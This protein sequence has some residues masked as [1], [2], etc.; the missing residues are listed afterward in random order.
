MVSL[1][2]A[3]VAVASAAAA[4]TG[5]GAAASVE[6]S[7]A[8][9][10]TMY[11]VTN[12]GPGE[13]GAFINAKGQVTFAHGDPMA[14]LPPR[15]WFFDGA[16]LHEVGTLGGDFARPTGLNDV[17]QVTGISNTASGFIHAFVWS[18]KQGMTDV[19]T[20]PGST[21]SWDPAINN[22][23]EVAGYSAGE[24]TPYPHAFRWSPRSGIE[25]L[26][27]LMPGESSTSYARAINDAGLIAGNAWAGEHFYHAFVWTRSAGMVDIDTLGSNYT[28]PVAVG[29]KGQ[30]AGN[31]I[32]P[33]NNYGSVFWWTRATGMRDIGAGQVRG[34]WMLSMSSGGRIAGIFNHPDF[35]QRAMTWTLQ[36]GMRDLGTLG[37]PTSF[38]TAANNRGQVVG[39]AS[40][41]DERVHAFVWTE[42]EGMA[43]LNQRLYRPPAGLVLESALGISDNGSIIAASN[44]GLVLLRPQQACPCAH[45]AGPIV[46]PALVQVGAP[47]DTAIAFATENRTARYQVSWAWGDGTAER[48]RET[49]ASHE[50][51]SASARHTYAA[52]GIYTITAKVADQAGNS[53][54]VSRRIVVLDSSSGA[55]GGAGAVVVPA[56][57][58][59]GLTMGGGKAHFSFVTPSPA[60]AK[61]AGTKGHF[62]FSL[63]GL[64]F[65]SNEVRV[66]GSQGGSV[67]LA[68]TGTLN[69]TGRHHFTATTSAGSS[70]G[71]AGRFRVKIWHTDPKTQAEVVDYDSQAGAN[72]NAGRPLVEGSVMVQ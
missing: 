11:R 27:L 14:G 32:N 26:G 8:A 12:L 7:H 46:S 24:P 10:P 57:T 18:K 29:A 40:T 70:K 72:G 25:D 60:R 65:A 30:V 69:G 37:G 48:A 67:H 34:T 1:A 44:A 59:K 43:D 28:V 49:H 17:G 4:Q 31:H 58:G 61:A 39:A 41:G 51:G 62:L 56:M 33:P 55:A 6:A 3:G 22:R 21:S 52:P 47:V 9:R 19:G 45:A 68:G 15:T 66:L 36:G 35:P 2:L 23:G 64:A 71:Q 20:L 13:T 50:G 38:A 53:A 54:T 16:R 63:P 5:P 42:K